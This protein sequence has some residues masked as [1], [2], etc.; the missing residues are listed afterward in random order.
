MALF[1]VDIKAIADEINRPESMTDGLIDMVIKVSKQAIQP[2]LTMAFANLYANAHQWYRWS[3]TN[4]WEEVNACST[5]I[6]SGEMVE[7][8]LEDGGP[9]DQDGMPN[10]FIACALGPGTPPTKA[11][12]SGNPPSVGESG[13]GG[14]GC[15]IDTIATS[16]M[17]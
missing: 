3:E 11:I 15:F 4:G 1:A 17:R 7:L 14:S 6:D 2:G 8:T 10:G 5:Q 16:W 13:S 12:S 9:G